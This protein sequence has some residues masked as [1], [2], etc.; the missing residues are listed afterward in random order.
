[1]QAYLADGL[2]AADAARAALG[3]DWSI[4]PGLPAGPPLAASARG[5]PHWPGAPGSPSPG[6]APRAQT[7]TAA[8]ARLMA[9]DP[10]TGAERA[11]WSR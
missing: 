7:A 3:G 9:G 1:M 8:G 2:S 10:V 6:P 5:S 11:G 4:P